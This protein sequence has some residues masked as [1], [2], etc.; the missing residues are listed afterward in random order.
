MLVSLL[1]AAAARV[2]LPS[3]VTKVNDTAVVSK[4][5]AIAAVRQASTP[6][7]TFTVTFADLPAA[8]AVKR[9]QR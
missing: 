8:L 4:A 7:K 9:V 5:D 3:L 6:G 2:T 1:L